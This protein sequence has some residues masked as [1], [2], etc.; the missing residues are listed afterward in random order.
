MPEMWVLKG[1]GDA[2][3][4]LTFRLLPGAEKTAGRA[5]RADFIIDAPLVSRVH[6]RFVVDADGTLTVEDLDSTNGTFL[7]GQRV[8]RAAVGDGDRLKIGRVELVATRSAG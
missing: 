5:V 7:N 2:G 1:A 6:C 8:G 3:G 4:E